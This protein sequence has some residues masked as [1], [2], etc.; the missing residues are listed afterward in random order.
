MAQELTHGSYL[1]QINTAHSN[2]WVAQKC[3]D[4]W[5]WMDNINTS[6]EEQMDGLSTKDPTF[7]Q[8]RP[9]VRGYLKTLPLEQRSKQGIAEL[10][11]AVVKGQNVDDIVERTKND[12]YEKFR[13]GELAGVVN[14]PT[15]GTFTQ[16]PVVT[17]NQ[18]SQEQLNAAAAMG[19]TAEEY[20]ANQK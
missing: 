4:V 8:Y 11:L 6:L 20:A 3:H 7:N 14:P 15:A 5:E 2:A 12:L 18:L 13:K 9:Q 1:A 17:A 16:P 10:A 19:M